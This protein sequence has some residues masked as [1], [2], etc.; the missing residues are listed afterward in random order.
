MIDPVIRSRFKKGHQIPYDWKQPSSAGNPEISN[1]PS[2]VLHI[3]RS[4]RYEM[5]G[6]RSDVFITGDRVWSM[7]GNTIRRWTSR[8]IAK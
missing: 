4:T 1:S 8:P 3:A 6:D 5:C 2:P 7:A